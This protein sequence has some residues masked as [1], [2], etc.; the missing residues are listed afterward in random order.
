MGALVTLRIPDPERPGVARDV[1]LPLEIEQQGP[2]AVE[3]FYQSPPAA[4]WQAAPEV[5]T[6][7]PAVPAEESES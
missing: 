1:P 5:V 3:A 7:L 2:A 6:E 4:L